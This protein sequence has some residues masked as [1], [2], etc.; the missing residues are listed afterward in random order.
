MQLRD[1]LSGQ[2]VITNIWSGQKLYHRHDDNTPDMIIGWNKGYRASWQTVIG[3]ISTAIFE[4]ND[5]KWSG[6]HCIDPAH[7]PA[8]FLINKKIVSKVPALPDVTATIL[9]LCDIP[10]PKQMTGESLIKS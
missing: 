7:V 8:T 9:S 5:D 3:E 4:D 2:K 6:E 10:I 1:P